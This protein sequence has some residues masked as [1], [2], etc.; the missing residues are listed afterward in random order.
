LHDGSAVVLAGFG[1]GLSWAAS[2]L[3]WGPTPGRVGATAP[4]ADI[5]HD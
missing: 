2:A 4:P 5:V 3:R 1:S